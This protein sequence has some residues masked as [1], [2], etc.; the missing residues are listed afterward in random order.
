[1]RSIEDVAL[2]FAR[3]CRE[4][5]VPYAFMGGMAVTFW[6][7]PRATMDID[8]LLRLTPHRVEGLV[9]R[10]RLHGLEASGDD[11]HAAF[12]DR[13]HVTVHDPVSP[14]HVDVKLAL[15]PEERAEIESAV[16]VV[17]DPPPAEAEIRVV[18]QEETIAFK[19]KFGSPQDMADARS[20]LNRRRAPL[21]VERLRL[22]AKRI[23]VSAQV[24]A[25]LQESERH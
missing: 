24:E 6:G 21:D 16:D 25:L 8:A 5:D 12:S 13:S 20:I 19:A 10:L 23:G 15:T 9:E 11:F 22:V 2:S 17:L 1:M 7:M 3:A 4:A 18:G 14:W